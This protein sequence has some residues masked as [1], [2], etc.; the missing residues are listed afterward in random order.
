MVVMEGETSGAQQLT[1]GREGNPK[2]SPSDCHPGGSTPCQLQVNLVDLA[3]DELW[4]LLEVTLRELNAPP[5]TH[6]Q[7]LGGIQ[8]EWGS[9][10]GWLGGHLS[11]RGMVGTC[12]T[13]N[14]TTCSYTIRWRWE[15]RGQ[16]PHPPASTQ[17]NGDMGYLINTLATG[18]QLGTPCINTFSAKAMPGKREVSFERCYHEVLCI[19]PLPRV[20]GQREYHMIAK[21]ASGYGQIYG[22]YHQHSPS[23][24]KINS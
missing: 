24:P 10:C 1:P 2:H 7:H 5:G 4:Q 22:P 18:L 14:S 8:W 17:P 11:E 19:R 21:G 16:P 15:S 6:C 3:D 20:N 12:R 9:W 23:P 13:T